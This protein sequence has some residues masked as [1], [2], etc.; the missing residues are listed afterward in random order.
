MVSQSGKFSKHPNPSSY[1]WFHSASSVLSIYCLHSHTSCILMFVGFCDFLGYV[2]SI[3]HCLHHC[4][5][6]LYIYTN[7]LHFLHLC[8]IHQNLNVPQSLLLTSICECHVLL[9]RSNHKNFKS[10]STL[11]VHE[12]LF[13]SGKMFKVLP[14]YILLAPLCIRGKNENRAN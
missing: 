7:S 9:C 10:P 2:P 1:S 3:F 14:F 13:P 8:S 11:H 4:V 6:I 12:N 5:H